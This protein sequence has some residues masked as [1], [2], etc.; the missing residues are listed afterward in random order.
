MDGSGAEWMGRTVLAPKEIIKAEP[1][2]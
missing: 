2:H 1:P